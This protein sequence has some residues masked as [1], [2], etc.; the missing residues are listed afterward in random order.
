MARKIYKRQEKE[1][2]KTNHSITKYFHPIQNPHDP[3]PKK[4]LQHKPHEINKTVETQK[5]KHQTKIEKYI[6]KKITVEPTDAP[7]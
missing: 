1:F 3:K 7:T 6:A 2:Y 4:P 5:H